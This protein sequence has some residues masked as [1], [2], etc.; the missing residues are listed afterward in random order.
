MDATNPQQPSNLNS[1]GT[2]N[3]T[4]FFNNYFI[5]AYT[6]SSNTN[7][8]IVSYFQQQTGGLDSAKL[9]AQ[10]VINTAQAQ[11]T[12]PL[13]IL[14]EFQKLSDNQINALLALYLNSSRVNTSFLAVKN[15]PKSN[16][17]IIRSILV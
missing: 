13:S 5:P 8:A 6:V 10:T 16:R 17:F 1:S 15:T 2:N 14:N 7:D 9:L 3:T 11:R 12:D 4:R